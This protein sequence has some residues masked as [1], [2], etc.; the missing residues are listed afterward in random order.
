VKQLAALA[1][2]V[3]IGCGPLATSSP[4]PFS[5][6]RFDYQSFARA[7]PDLLEP[8]YLPF[9]AHRM[10]PKK[11]D[12]DLIVF[13]RWD[14]GR[15]PLAVWVDA[16]EIGE[17]LQNEFN[18]KEPVDFVDAAWRALDSW[19]HALGG[20]PHFRRAESASSSDLQIELI[21]SEGPKP[22]DK[23]VLGATPLQRACQLK[24]TTV[25]GGRVDVSFEVPRIQVYIAD[26]YG[27]LPADQVERNVLHEVGHA[28]GMRGHSPIP[29]DLMY[30]VARDRRVERLSTEDVHSFRA[31]YALP[32]G[33]VYAT[34][35]HANP[36]AR[37]VAH[38]PAGPPA[39][40]AQPWVDEG[41][42]FSMRVADGWRLVGAPRG[43]VAIDGLAWDYEA[44]FQVIVR[45]YPTI[46]AYVRRH[47]NGHLRGGELLAQGPLQV[48]GRPAFH[49]T[50][51]QDGGAMIEE[52]V[53]VETGDGRVV[54]V[55]EEAP[56]ELRDGFQ[57][58]F[59]AMLA[60]LEI[61]RPGALPVEPASEAAAASP[62]PAPPAPA[63]AGP[64]TTG[65]PAAAAPAPAA[66]TLAPTTPAAAPAASTQAEPAPPTPTPTAPSPAASSPPA[67]SSPAPSPPARTWTPSSKG[68]RGR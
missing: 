7:H 17:P 34:V 27:L 40:I 12:Q 22:G 55:I 53:F 18:P 8:N 39:L 30:E 1:G 47:G 65:A 36:T 63:A 2:V 16:P 57:P 56:A 48:A 42:G 14:D 41:L 29:A 67:P 37:P 21:G 62:A 60:S 45:S 35:P 15:F 32:N 25:H 49:M 9:M 28:L 10:S 20:P 4:E 5:P 52:H 61:L 24:S 54:V 50:V 58:W 66:A 44:S 33:T 11:G 59:D 31:L 19:Q 51:A 68:A 23:Q 6:T 3:T 46:A 26:Q 43:I 38:A 13:C 64:A